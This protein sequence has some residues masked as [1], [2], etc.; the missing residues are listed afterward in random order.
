M[1]VL[2]LEVNLIGSDT[3]SGIKV[4]ER[5]NIRYIAGGLQDKGH[6]VMVYSKNIDKVDYDTLD[7]FKPDIIC[8]SS[9]TDPKV[10]EWAKTQKAL[11]SVGT[12]T[13]IELEHGKGILKNR[14]DLD[15][16][17]IGGEP[18]NTW[19][20][21]LD[22]ITAEKGFENVNGIVYRQNDE[23]KDNGE[24]QAFNIKDLKMFDSGEVETVL[25]T[26]LGCIG[27]CTFCS[28]KIFHKKWQ[29]RSIES[30]I[31]EIKYYT[32]KGRTL[33][34]FAD[35]ELEAPDL[36]LQRLA[37]LCK[38]IIDIGRPIHYKANFR[39][40]FSRKATPEIMDLLVES[41]LYR[42][43][44]GVES[45]SQDDLNLYNKRCTVQEAKDTVKLF[46]D[47]GIYTEIGFIMFNP[48]STLNRLALN[49]DMLEEI[50]RADFSSIFSY[51]HANVGDRL[52]NTAKEAGLHNGAIWHFKDKK[53][54]LLF[55]F[56]KT[57][58]D[59]IRPIIDKYYKAIDG[60]SFFW[61]KFRFHS[62]R[63][64][65]EICSIIQ[66]YIDKVFYIQRGMNLNLCIWFRRLIELAQQEE[67]DIEQA[68]GITSSLLNEG[69]INEMTSNLENETN[70]IDSA[71]NITYE[72]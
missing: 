42:A 23:I 48:F 15:F 38:E 66:S 41:G 37:R 26:S 8:F 4:Y 72:E 36:K 39:P 16:I 11:K 33:F 35:A 44:I 50:G 51:Y 17:V 2:F 57:Y 32:D 6:N 31:E 20:D 68:I 18:Y 52:A 62:N 34:H 71:L 14:K 12:G 56:I 63:G 10:A 59:I 49:I 46:T 19:I 65:E 7:S 29:G 53:V 47:Y 28:D 30:V 54:G 70:K 58:F 61:C 1:N 9:Y 22:S 43:Y 13:V 40:D 21:L 60:H 55:F 25:T 5:R 27:N 3:Y 64:E 69:F 24:S 45:G 67:F